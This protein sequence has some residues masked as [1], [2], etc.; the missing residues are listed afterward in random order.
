M[1][2]MGVCGV[3][4]WWYS[5]LFLL[6]F[7]KQCPRK[8]HS[9]LQQTICGFKRAPGA[10]TWTQSN[11]HES[12]SVLWH[13][14]WL[15]F[16]REI[17]HKPKTVL[18]PMIFVLTFVIS[19]YFDPYADLNTLLTLAF[20]KLWVTNTPSHTSTFHIIKSLFF[21]VFIC[22]S[23]LLM[24]QWFNHKPCHYETLSNTI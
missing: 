11:S 24:Q 9:A 18:L 17:S 16:H 13:G 12:F 1:R 22:F 14:H 3:W 10:E 23:T 4:R 15:M 19:P 20:A 21:S 6:L 8:C 2:V 5:S 7:L